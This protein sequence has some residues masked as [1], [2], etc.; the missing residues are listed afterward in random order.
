[1]YKVKRSVMKAAYVVAKNLAVGKDVICPACG[2]IFIKKSYQQA[3]CSGRCKD[4][5]W[6][7]L[8]TPKQHKKHAVLSEDT[9]D[10]DCDELDG[11]LTRGDEDICSN[12]DNCY[13]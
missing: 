12:F 1:M 13:N 6:N 10:S 4:G 8:K 7:S 9:L 2:S 3:F 5:Y 11:E